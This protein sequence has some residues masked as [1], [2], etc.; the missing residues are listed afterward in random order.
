MRVFFLAM[1]I[2][3]SCYIFVSPFLSSATEYQIIH[4]DLMAMLHFHVAFINRLLPRRPSFRTSDVQI[5]CFEFQESIKCI[6]ELSY[7]IMLLLPAEIYDLL[8]ILQSSLLWGFIWL[9]STVM[10]MLHA[11]TEP[12]LTFSQQIMQWKTSKHISE[13]SKLI[14]PF[15]EYNI[16]VGG[17]CSLLLLGLSQSAPVHN[18]LRKRCQIA[19]TTDLILRIVPESYSQLQVMTMSLFHDYI[20]WLYSI[21]GFVEMCQ[22][23]FSVFY[24]AHALIVL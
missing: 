4:R 24:K 3:F 1:K 5:L 6:L 18:T 9:L 20:G 21:S 22:S 19:T 7:H 15:T 13:S 14:Q 23:G 8:Q 16:T 11:R 2:L 12:L 17:N 10:N